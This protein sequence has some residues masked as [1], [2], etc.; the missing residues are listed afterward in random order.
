MSEKMTA[1][2]AKA[3]VLAVYPDAYVH[4]HLYEDSVRVIPVYTVYRPQPGHEKDCV[5]YLS[6]EWSSTK[7]EAWISAASHL[8]A[9][10]V[11]KEE[12]KLPI[13]RPCS[14]CS[15]GDPEMKYHDHYPPFSASVHFNAD[16]A[17]GPGYV[18]K[19]SL[20]TVQREEE[21]SKA[22]WD[23]WE[24]YKFYKKSDKENEISASMPE[25]LVSDKDRP[26]IRP[27]RTQPKMLWQ[28]Y[29]F[30]MERY[31]VK[32]EKE[33]QQWRK[34]AEMARRGWINQ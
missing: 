21:S 10:K 8:L 22:S 19:H 2:E 13:D 32:L 11:R 17:G 15:G 14:A 30:E 1:E 27:T 31:I 23:S 5:Q 6:N 16:E 12:R 18:K 34:W 3:K 20:P 26:K 33:L 25:P 4:K 7:E 9:E 29:C 28:S 24:M